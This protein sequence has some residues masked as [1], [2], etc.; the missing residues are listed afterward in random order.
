VNECEASD[1]L[2]EF[3]RK[4]S[5]FMYPSFATIS[6]S[7]S[8]A[9]IIHYRPEPTTC[10]VIDKNQIYLCDSGGQYK[11]GTTD[12]T[13]TFHF[14]KPSE[15]E[16]Q[17]YTGVLKGHIAFDSLTFPMNISGLQLDAFARSGLWAL[18]LDYRHGTGHGV[19]HFLCVHEGPQSVSFRARSMSH[20]FVEN[21]TITNEPGYY[22]DGKFGIRIENI[23]VT[24]EKKT[25][26]NFGGKFLAFEHITFVPLDRN[27][28]VVSMLTEEEKKWVNSYH[29]ECLE[30]VGELMD[31]SEKAYKWLEER[32]KAL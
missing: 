13:R 26:N 3:R 30:K 2:L 14:G 21:M 28:I 5:D 11:D 15:K 9:A 17:C 10:A 6:S 25:P 20:S 4:V 27:L 8:N 24:V 1:K 12:V 19:G 16:K 29:K 23:L 7:G 32:T 31:K 18:G 22:E